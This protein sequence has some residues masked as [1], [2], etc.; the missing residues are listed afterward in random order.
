MLF[1]V[2]LAT[3]EQKS[4]FD[5]MC[6]SVINLC[7]NRF[8]SSQATAASLLSPVR[9][10]L[11]AACWTRTGAC[12]SNIFERLY[13][14]PR[15]PPRSSEP[16]HLSG[17]IVAHRVGSIST[18]RPLFQRWDRQRAWAVWTVQD[19]NRETLQWACQ[20][21]PGSIYSKLIA[22][23]VWFDLRQFPHR[24]KV[25]NQLWNINFEKKGDFLFIQKLP[26]FVV[27]DMSYDLF[28]P[29]FKKIACFFLFAQNARFPINF[30][31]FSISLLSM[32]LP[33]SLCVLKTHTR[34]DRQEAVGEKK[35]RR[36]IMSVFSLFFLLTQ[37][38]LNNESAVRVWEGE[39]VPQ[40]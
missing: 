32:S 28:A 9:H 24:P 33:F 2:L 16:L 31:F 39:K 22:R 40:I 30:K 13:S 15:R 37:E 5:H 17:D 27:G 11:D 8:T 6:A 19:R 34:S 10:C 21:S 1:D 7:N 35:R 23:V 38:E 20:S 12:S 18:R 3:K 26:I 14:S 25:T 36:K 4:I 29:W